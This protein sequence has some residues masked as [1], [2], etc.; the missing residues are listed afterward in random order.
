MVP[1]QRG[2]KARPW[3]GWALRIIPADDKVGIDRAVFDKNYQPD[4]ASIF[5]EEF[6][7]VLVPRIRLKSGK[8]QNRFQFNY[9]LK[10]SEGLQRAE[11]AA[12]PNLKSRDV[13]KLILN[14]YDQGKQTLCLRN[15]PL[16]AAYPRWIQE[17]E[18]PKCPDCARRML[19][20]RRRR[21]NS[22]A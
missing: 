16:F 2:A 6:V 4:V 13:Q 1:L 7:H 21:S 19:H 14:F 20:L 3:D 15:C 9:Y 12:F 17:P 5:G 18:F 8:E 10:E 22:G 11:K